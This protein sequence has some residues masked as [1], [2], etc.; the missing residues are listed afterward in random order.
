MT[1]LLAAAVI[2]VWT[3][4]WEP[5]P[6]T[7]LNRQWVRC[8]YHFPDGR[9]EWRVFREGSCPRTIEVKQS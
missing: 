9:L 1:A 6:G 2:A 8:L 3:G 4:Q 7:L 5:M